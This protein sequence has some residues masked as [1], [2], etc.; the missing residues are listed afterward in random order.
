MR[1]A[2]NKFTK[3]KSTIMRN[4]IATAALLIMSA[5]SFSQSLNDILSGKAEVSAE[6]SLKHTVLEAMVSENGTPDQVAVFKVNGINN[7]FPYC[8]NGV[9]PMDLM[10]YEEADFEMYASFRASSDTVFCPFY[11]KGTY[12]IICFDADMN[13]LGESLVVMMNDN[14]INAGLSQGFYSINNNI[15][16]SN[17]PMR[18][19]RDEPE[20]LCFN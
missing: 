18:I 6:T 19:A 17:D 15:V 13:E 9:L 3:F 16:R 7:D 2:T 14:F 11:E 20:F 1:S 5:T 10:T 4:Y 8:G 12:L